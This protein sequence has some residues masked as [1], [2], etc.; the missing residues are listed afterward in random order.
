MWQKKQTDSVQWFVLP[1]AFATSPWS[2]TDATT[3]PIH[4]LNHFTGNDI[5]RLPCLLLPLCCVLLMS[6][7]PFFMGPGITSPHMS[8]ATACHCGD[9]TANTLAS[10][11]LAASGKQTV[12]GRDVEGAS[13]WQQASRRFKQMWHSRTHTHTHTPLALAWLP[14]VP[15]ATTYVEDGGGTSG[16]WLSDQKNIMTIEVSCASYCLCWHFPYC[17][18][19]GTSGR[20]P[21]KRVTTVEE[22]F[23]SMYMA[24]RQHSNES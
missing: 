21:P 6:R 24:L 8:K 22:A 13:A 11:Y 19:H 14:A 12:E 16:L 7:P 5:K 15:F 3:A 20:M 17:R 23:V 4:Q 2:H 18:C 9:N 1:D 10:S